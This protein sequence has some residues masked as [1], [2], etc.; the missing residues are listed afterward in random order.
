MFSNGFVVV[1]VLLLVLLPRWRA[2][3][4]AAA[5]IMLAGVSLSLL[6]PRVLKKD[7]P[8]TIKDRDDNDDGVAARPLESFRP[9]NSDED[10]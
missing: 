3:A 5:G 4:A 10:R 6:L 9:G 2:A 7:P 1:G 8:R